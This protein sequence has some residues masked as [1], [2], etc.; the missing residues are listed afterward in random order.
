MQNLA[1]ML[2]KGFVAALGFYVAAVF[3]VVCGLGDVSIGTLQS[4]DLTACGLL[5]FGFGL[6]CDASARWAIVHCPRCGYYKDG[7]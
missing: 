5:M 3:L 1:G 4:M 7:N 2:D 6:I